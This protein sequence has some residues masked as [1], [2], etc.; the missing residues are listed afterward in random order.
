MESF[1][2]YTPQQICIITG[3]NEE[4]EMGGAYSIN[5]RKEKCMRSYGRKT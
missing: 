3:S 5:A 1:I 2:I 4:Y